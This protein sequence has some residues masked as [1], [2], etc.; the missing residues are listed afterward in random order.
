MKKN[1]YIEF[2]KWVL[3][4]GLF[5][6]SQKEIQKILDEQ[7]E[8]G[9][10]CTHYQLALMPKLGIVQLILIYLVFFCTLGFV[11]FWVGAT[12]LFEKEV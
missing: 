5:L 2:R 12:L 1:K 11:Q 10:T 8:E 9:W 4:W 7:N 6:D 3:F